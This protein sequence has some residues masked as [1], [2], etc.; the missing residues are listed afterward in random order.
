MK[1]WFDYF[2]TITLFDEDCFNIENQN[3]DDENV[4]SESLIKDQQRLTVKN[5]KS[6]IEKKINRRL[7]INQEVFNHNQWLVF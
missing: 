5:R 6:K 4:I 1:Q 7:V 2:E 3:H